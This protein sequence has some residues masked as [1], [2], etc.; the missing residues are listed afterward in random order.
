MNRI[1]LFLLGLLLIISNISYS[2]DSVYVNVSADIVNQYINRGQ[3]A[4]GNSAHIQPLLYIDYKNFEVGAW[5]VM[6]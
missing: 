5:V 3:N 4:G 1:K 2:Q 6:V